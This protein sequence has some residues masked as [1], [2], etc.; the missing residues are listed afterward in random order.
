MSTFAGWNGPPGPPWGPGDETW[1][2]KRLKALDDQWF[3]LYNRFNRLVTA[4]Y[5]VGSKTLADFFEGTMNAQP[6]AISPGG[7]HWR[8]APF[9]V[10][11]RALA[12]EEVVGDL[13]VSGALDVAGSGHIEGNLTV[14]GV[15]SDLTVS[16]AAT[17]GGNISARDA[18]LENVSLHDLDAN[19]I[20]VL[21]LAY[22]EVSSRLSQLRMVEATAGQWIPYGVLGDVEF[23]NYVPSL[24]VAGTLNTTEPDEFVPLGTPV[25]VEGHVVG[26][27]PLS[28]GI[29]SVAG[30]LEILQL[31]GT[32]TQAF[33]LR[34]VWNQG[35]FVCHVHDPDHYI[36]KVGIHV[37]QQS[38]DTAYV[39]CVK[40]LQPLTSGQ[41]YYRTE[42]C[43]GWQQVR[44]PLTL[45]VDN[46]TNSDLYV[47]RSPT[48]SDEVLIQPVTL[49]DL[50][51]NS[52]TTQDL[53]ATGHS[54]LNTA[55]IVSLVADNL[56]INKYD[57]TP[58]Q[59]DFR[60]MSTPDWKCLDTSPLSDKVNNNQV[61]GEIFIYL[62]DPTQIEELVDSVTGLP[63][64]PPRYAP[65]PGDVA[66]QFIWINIAKTHWLVHSGDDT[67][68]FVDELGLDANDVGYLHFNGVPCFMEVVVI[69][70]RD[71]NLEV[72]NNQSVP[73]SHMPLVKG[74]SM[75]TL[76]AG[77]ASFQN[78]HSVNAV[79]DNLTVTHGA[80]IQEDVS[81]GGDTSIHGALLVNGLEPDGAAQTGMTIISTG[82]M[83]S[84]GYAA[85]SKGV[86]SP[87]V[88]TKAVLRGI[89]ED[90]IVQ[91]FPAS[92]MALSTGWYKL[93]DCNLDADATLGDFL[94]IRTSH[95]SCNVTASIFDV[96]QV[97]LYGGVV[98]AHFLDI[99]FEVP[100]A[101]ITMEALPD[102]KI[103]FTPS[104][105]LQWDFI[106]NIVPNR[107][108]VFN[109]EP[110][111]SSATTTLVVK[112][113]GGAPSIELADLYKTINS[114]ELNIV[115]S[116]GGQDTLLINGRPMTGST[117][118]S[119]K[120][121]ILAT[122]WSATS[123]VFEARDRVSL[124]EVNGGYPQVLDIV[125]TRNATGQTMTSPAQYLAFHGIP[126]VTVQDVLSILEGNTII[127]NTPNITINA[128]DLKIQN[129]TGGVTNRTLV[130]RDS[131]D[132]QTLNIVTDAPTTENKLTVNGNSLASSMD[133]FTATSKG[134]V[135]MAGTHTSTEYLGAD[136]AWHH[137][138]DD[139]GLQS[140]LSTIQQSINTEVSDRLVSDGVFTADISAEQLARVQGDQA[141]QAQITALGNLGRFLSTVP[142]YAALA[143]VV[144]PGS[145]TIGDYVNVLVDE[146]HG[147][148]QTRYRI[149][150]LTPLTWVYDGSY[151]TDT[152]GKMDKVPTALY[153]NIAVFN[154]IGQ[155]VDGGP[156]AAVIG[157]GRVLG[158]VDTVPQLPAASATVAVGDWYLV[159]RTLNG[160][161]G[162]YI[163]SNKDVGTNT[164]TWSLG[165]RVVPSAPRAYYATY[166]DLPTSSLNIVQGT[167]VMVLADETRG[168]AITCYEA[169][170]AA[171]GS[172][173]TWT[174][175]Y[176][177]TMTVSVGNTLTG[178]GS[179]SNP[180]QV[181]EAN[182]TQLQGHLTNATVHITSA[183]RTAW[184]AKASQTDLDAHTTNTGIHVTASDKTAWNAKASQA[185]LNAHTS[186]TTVHVSTA[187][188]TR[189]TN[190]VQ[191]TQ[192]TEDHIYS[193]SSAASTASA[194]NP[195]WVCFFPDGT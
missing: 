108:V 144:V 94:H 86:R 2:V 181:N 12:G 5:G 89:N 179:A 43:M 70:R 132:A 8:N 95:G 16:G 78:S 153:G 141:L 143:T 103:Y 50:Y 66:R 76:S 30:V 152:S 98:Y 14:G 4:A 65:R 11:L 119:G 24:P 116:S 131:V 112:D 53:T 109:P 193:T 52:V 176:S 125:D 61:S 75:P 19:S 28:A 160:V 113:L 107:E 99:F 47:Q 80:T 130:F 136:A 159:Q 180:L 67:L 27:D 117:T 57:F 128:T 178:N 122:D 183:E 49:N 84:E 23:S 56:V 127:N 55:H 36:D 161:A 162:A 71:F 40:F 92:F 175:L 20:E 83:L 129:P 9:T 164:L 74:M 69:A 82:D 158:F 154:A 1:I 96:D 155:V 124:A 168:G 134:A 106:K 104:G 146:T 54:E 100:V 151:S 145:A 177:I 81:I 6:S 21:R 39:L 73:I 13:A 7:Y 29:E 123:R 126:L 120:L 15:S 111:I 114:N 37:I 189:I 172:N 101:V 133:V 60:L 169:Q 102:G 51:A 88:H 22:T 142:N 166:A 32:N 45:F 195:T 173:I 148:V 174:Y 59:F 58:V 115:T 167:C 91:R 97:A 31:T 25:E 87:F 110:A 140:A 194:S 138:V 46:T 26:T 93:W 139:T 184:N 147:N 118:L 18:A 157:S 186:N 68:D 182:L 191:S 170:V 64:V 150:S 188:A 10:K 85:G 77:M 35:A 165:W 105:V 62:Y 42:N 17:I 79:D 3:E 41:A 156:L 149:G 163:C 34:C 187:Q 137:I 48:L 33:S 121:A 90:Q 135:P 63:Y 171:S 72:H 190:A 44:Y 192:I 185:D 38:G